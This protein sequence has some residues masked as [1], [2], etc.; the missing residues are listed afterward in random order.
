MIIDC[1]KIKE[2]KIDYLKNEINNLNKKPKLLIIVVGDDY[3]SQVYVRNKKILGEQ[4][5][6]EVEINNVDFDISEEQL[7]A[8]IT[9]ANNDDEVDGLFVQLPV[10]KHICEER[11]IN[12]IS[13]QKD[14]DGFSYISSGKLM[15]GTKAMNPCTADAVISILNSIDFEFEGSNVVIA[16]RSNIVGK[17]LANLLINLGATVTVANSKTKNIKKHISGADVFISAIGNANYFDE[18]YFEGM[19]NLIAIDVGI[20]RD[21]NGKLCGDIKTNEVEKHVKA[22]TSVPGGVGVLTVVHVMKN[23]LIAVKREN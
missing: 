1:K 5:G 22:I 20:N 6:V 11:I 23:M 2:E 15:A 13:P 17:P 3:S 21:E 19:N 12:A 16:G 9:E 4:I 18:T 14:I 10:P 7:I 8:K